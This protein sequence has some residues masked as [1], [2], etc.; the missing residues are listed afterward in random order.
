MGNTTNKDFNLV[1]AEELCLSYIKVRQAVKTEFISELIS[2]QHFFGKT[3]IVDYKLSLSRRYQKRTVQSVLEDLGN[4]KI[5]DFYSQTDYGCHGTGK[6][7][8]SV[9]TFTT[10]EGL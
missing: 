8:Y 2:Y 4:Y 6:H 1:K 3:S 9:I 10:A 7:T 5:V